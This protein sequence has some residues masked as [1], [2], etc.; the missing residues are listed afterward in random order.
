MST[1]RNCMWILMTAILSGTAF[2]GILY[3]QLTLGSL[4]GQITDQSGASVPNCQ[5]EVKNLETGASRVVESNASGIYTVAALPTSRYQ[6]TASKKG[7]KGA[8]AEVSVGLG[9]TVTANFRL[10]LGSVSQTVK[11]TASSGTLALQKQSHVISQI[12]DER[13]IDSLP[14][15]GRNILSLATLGPGSQ[16]GGDLINDSNNGGTAQYFGVTNRLVILGGQSVGHT[17]FLQDGVENVSLFTQGINILPDPDATQEVSVDTNGMSAKYSQPSVVNI[18][19]KSGSNR[20]HGSV[21]DYFKNRVLNSASFFQNLYGQDKGVF[22]YNQ[23]GGTIGGPIREN[24][25][26]FF[27]NY[28]GVRDQSGNLFAGRIPTMAERQGDF[29]DYLTGVPAGGGTTKT[30]TITDPLTGL[31]FPGNVIPPD[32]IS[33][34]AK[35]FNQFWPTPTSNILPDGTN[36]AANLRSTDNSNQ[37]LGRVDLNLSQRDTLSGLF[38][39]YNAPSISNSF[40]PNTFGNTYKRR[41]INSA[42]EETHVFSPDLLNVARV[43]YNRSIFFNSELGVGAKDWVSL[44][45]LKNLN[46]TI[47][48]NDPPYVVIN[49]VGIGL[50]NPFAPQGAIQNRYQFADEVDY[51]HQK[52]NISTG[53]E[54]DRVQFNG[55]WELVNSGFFQFNGQYSGLGLADLLLGYPFFAWGSNGHTLAGF[56]E[57][58]FAT[59]FQDNWRILPK[60]TLNLGVR[61]QY[62]SPPR[63]KY[64]HAATFSLTQGKSVPGSWDPNTRDFAPRVGFA[65]SL[66]HNTVIRSGFGIYYTSTPYNVLQFLMANPPNFLSVIDTFPQDQPT[67]ISTLFPPFTPGVTVFAPFALQKRNPDAYMEQ[68]NFD[69]QHSL[70]GNLLLSVA[71]V[72]DA[73]H[74]L[75]IRLNPNMAHQPQT[76]L[77]PA[78]IQQRRPYPALGDVLAQYPLGN[79]NYNAFQVSLRKHWSSGLSFLAGYTWSK[80]FDLLSTDGGYVINGLDPERN[81]AP[82]D[83]NRSQNFVFSYTYQLP[84]GTGKPFLD[85]Q[86][87]FS[88]Y[89]VGGWQVNGITSF[90]SGLPFSVQTVTDL[91]NTGANHWY[92]ADR[93]CNGNLPESQRTRLRWFDTSCFVQPPIGRLGNTGR[94]VLL[95]G[96]I[97]NWD[98][99]LFKTFPLG[100]SRSLEFRADTFNL[101]NQH[102]FSYNE[103]GSALGSAFYGEATGTTTGPRVVQL[104][105]KMLF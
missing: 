25:A 52:H 102:Q 67:S 41:G 54:F 94:N 62:N 26:F 76:P 80:S 4:T 36:Y 42:I 88:K 82:S 92:Y 70:P 10:A 19:T 7:F 47:E 68:W 17:E 37:Y 74:H 38:Q 64:G 8:T 105:L 43:G 99:S 69:I 93:V 98:F 30:V 101:F 31:P 55:N 22:Q 18:V 9:Q 44:F 1:S 3:A 34:F 16:P 83:F 79:S 61:Y 5:I 50:G 90:S 33:S 46:P 87:W 24:R 48:Q 6:I 75:S 65:Y 104:A 95:M 51:T 13:Q 71:Y 59:Y 40:V 49:D 45:G 100:E 63:D 86:N 84:F 14:M 96:G 27:F 85:R 97:K 60:L 73:G 2:A 32:Q 56:R 29:S 89:V 28:E 53:A 12:V 23:F 81:Y 58:D 57:S 78:P 20:F 72:G 66:T 11:V 77:N 91:S 103:A 35:D 21:Y 15:N 39:S